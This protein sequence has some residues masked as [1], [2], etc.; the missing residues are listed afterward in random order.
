MFTFIRAALLAGLLAILALPSA[1]ASQASKIP[2]ATMDNQKEFWR[3]FMREIYGPYDVEKKCWIG[4]QSGQTYCM[5]PNTFDLVTINDQK[6]LYVTA[7]GKQVGQQMEHCQN[8]P[9][10]IGFFVLTPGPLYFD[11]A[12]ES[13]RYAEEGTF[14]TA[15][16]TENMTL[17]QISN[18]GDYA[19][20]AKINSF[21]RGTFF[22]NAVIYAAKRK[23]ISAI[24]ILPLYYNDTES[25]C[26][27]SDSNTGVGC[28][29]YR[30]ELKIRQAEPG[31]FAP[32]EMSLKGMVKGTDLAKTYIATFDAQQSTYSLPP[33]FPVN[34]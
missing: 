18:S 21:N 30:I 4:R 32:V 33:D 34:E 8:C 6:Q 15:P 29:D 17:Q 22:E 24:G 14:N 10:N 5:Y 31:T 19:W 16:S 9:G 2:I 27:N 25:D 13:D 20:I 3:A 28:S 23:V 11:I 26:I 1:L 7:S 12:A